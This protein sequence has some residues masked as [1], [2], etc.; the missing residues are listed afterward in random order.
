M[1]PPE[2]V[3]TDTMGERVLPVYLSL[4]QAADVMAMSVKTVRRRI[5]DGTIPAYRCGRGT[6]RIRLDELECALRRVPAGG[7]VTPLD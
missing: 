7:V 3:R 1:A 6:I 5:A 2:A 4:E